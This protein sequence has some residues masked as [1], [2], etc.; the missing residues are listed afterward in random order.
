M[1]VGDRTRMKWSKLDPAACDR[2]VGPAP[3]GG[4][5]PHV[6]K[7]WLPVPT[8][9]RK[10]FAGVKQDRLKLGREPVLRRQRRRGRWGRWR[11]GVGGEKGVASTCQLLDEA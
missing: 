11:K 1:G 6:L 10:I 8:K 4:V 9:V 3:E 2:G 5:V 7:A